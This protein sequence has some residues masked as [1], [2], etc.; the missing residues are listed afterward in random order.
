LPQFEALS[1]LSDS[2]NGNSASVWAFSDIAFF[3]R[4]ALRDAPTDPVR[5][6]C[7]TA[8]SHSWRDQ[9]QIEATKDAHRVGIAHAKGN[10]ATAVAASLRSHA[11]RS[12]RCKRSWPA[13]TMNV[14]Q[15]GPICIWAPLALACDGIEQS[16]IGSAK[17]ASE[18]AV[19]G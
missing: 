14:L 10:D 9:A 11:S 4:A 1:S 3:T 17:T 16:K 8:S 2:L 13:A 18:E 12:A 6:L 15:S 5:K 7:G 19:S